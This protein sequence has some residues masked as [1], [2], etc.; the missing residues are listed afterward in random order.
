MVTSP[1]QF[2]RIEHAQTYLMK[3][4][5]RFKRH[6]DNVEG[7]F[8]TRNTILRLRIAGM[9]VSLAVDV[10]VSSFFVERF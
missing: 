3:L 2:D 10:I 5:R 4:T 8:A 7:E 1:M 9:D 6:N